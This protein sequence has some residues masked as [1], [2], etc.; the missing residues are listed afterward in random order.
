MATTDPAHRH[1]SLPSAVITRRALLRGTG[2][3]AGG[4]LIGLH[5]PSR[6]AAQS[7]TAVPVI[8]RMNAWLHIGRDNRITFMLGRSEMGQG[9]HT[10]LATLIAEE[11][12]VDPLKVTIRNA[13]AD[14]AHRNI[15]MVKSMLSGN[16]ADS[17]SG[18]P[19]WALERLGRVIGQ[20]VTGG[21]TSLRDGFRTLRLAGAEARW[22]LV[23]AA[24]AKWGVAARDCEMAN[25][26]IT[27][28]PSG[29]TLHYG[30]VA[31]NAA[32]LE[33]PADIA[34]K[35][36]NAWRLIGTFDKRVDTP[37]KIDGS[38]V[39]GLDVRRDNQL[40]AAVQWGPH[41]GA[42]LKSLSADE[43]MKQPGI[44]AA[45]PL[46]EGFAVVADNSWRAMQA[47]DA[48]KAEWTPGPDSGF[49]DATL[50]SH[51]A[52]L[53]DAEGRTAH[54]AG[55]ADKAIGSAATILTT[56]YRLPFLAHA[57]MEP[58]NATAR[59][60]ADGLDIWA[61]TQAQEMAQ[62]AAA[63]ATGLSADRVRIHTTYLGGGFGRRAEADFIHVA[64]TV[65]KAI[66]GRAVQV[67][68]PREEDI[69]RDFY[70]PAALHRVKL[71]LDS[72]GRLVAWKHDLVTPSIMKR[73]FPPVTWMGP[74]QT[75]TEGCLDGSYRIPN[76][77]LKYVAADTPVPVGFWRSVGHSHSAFVKECLIDEAAHAAKQDPVSYRLALLQDRPRHRAVLD[78]AASRSGWGEVLPHGHGRGIALHESF[79][80]IVAMVAEVTVSGSAVKLDRITCAADAG[81]VVNPAIVMAQ[82]RGGAIFGLSAALYG[83]VTLKEAAVQESNFHDYRM[84]GM[85]EAPP[86]EVY[87]VPSDGPPGGIGEPGV[88][89]AAPAL[90]NAIFAAT[91]KR[92]RDMP[93]RLG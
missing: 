51:F 67:M 52:K 28:K 30:A 60:G 45:V 13:P 82:L 1:S 47:R 53:I 12:D 46:K 29:S 26:V 73:V 61:P 22:R 59:M 37:A 9:V 15:Y 85:A 72:A 17:L 68:W 10:G 2:L 49:D 81:T 41:F 3:A 56:E 58:M 79:G 66:T 21:S 78:L 90:A 69:R 74:D 27:H 42:T 87:L 89:P 18:L 65:A 6:A 44:H 71:G 62:K 24:A 36:R 7:T 11:L 75:A 31:D 76:T 16:Q 5:L 63:E 35:E 50:W 33:P 23:E 88:P 83:R 92:L 84:L 20:Q 39:F 54:T 48:V 57:T 93:L 91:G 8:S 86:V 70:R 34:L 40:F 32:R 77:A 38:A 64:A 14:K 25:G 19:L 43:A 4:L 55:D 80:T